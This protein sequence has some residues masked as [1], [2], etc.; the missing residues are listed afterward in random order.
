M[1]EIGELRALCQ[2]YYDR[3]CQIENDKYD[4]EKRVEFKEYEVS[5]LHITEGKTGKLKEFQGNP[6]NFR[7]CK[8][9]LI[10]ILIIDFI[11]DY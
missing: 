7:A 3:V 11:S 2:S 5:D 9:C 1:T 4:T 10:P 8:K 6:G